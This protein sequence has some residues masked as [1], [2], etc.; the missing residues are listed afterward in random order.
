MVLDNE[1]RLALYLKE[2][3]A[4]EVER[5]TFPLSFHFLYLLNGFSF[6]GSFM[7]DFW[8]WKFTISIDPSLLLH[9]PESFSFMCVSLSFF[10]FVSLRR[11]LPDFHAQCVARHKTG[12]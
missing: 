7:Q 2:T 4:K 10:F 3:S 12:M 5:L 6:E 9:G 11:L 8:K 1:H